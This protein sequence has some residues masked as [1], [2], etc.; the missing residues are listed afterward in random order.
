MSSYST[1]SIR[2][3]VAERLWNWASNQK[4]AGLIPCHAKIDVVSL[5]KALHLTYLRGMSLYLL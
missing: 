5:G 2:S 1:L 3:Q 4:V